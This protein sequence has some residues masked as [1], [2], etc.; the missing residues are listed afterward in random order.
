MDLYRGAEWPTPYPE[1]GDVAVIQIRQDR[2]PRDSSG[3]FSVMFDLGIERKFNIVNVRR[4]SLFCST[5]ILDAATYA[6]EHSMSGANGAIIQVEVAPSAKIIFNPQVSDSAFLTK[7]ISLD[8]H[9]FLESASSFEIT[10]NHVRQ[11]RNLYAQQTPEQ[12]MRTLAA[13]CELS[14][15]QTTAFMN[16]V[17]AAADALVQGY[18]MTTAG[19]FKTPGDHTECLITGVTEYTGYFLP[20]DDSY[21]D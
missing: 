13:K 5:Q 14:A 1:E 8:W 7:T 20:A 18:Q 4:K 17:Y 12:A 19:A 11:L 16:L 9:D 6:D 2:R 3:S 21:F 15:D 10:Q